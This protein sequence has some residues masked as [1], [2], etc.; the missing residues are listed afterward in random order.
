MNL[1]CNLT[2]SYLKKWKGRGKQIA[3]C[4]ISSF[5]DTDHLQ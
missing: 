2:L 3:L 5:G 1:E 4:L